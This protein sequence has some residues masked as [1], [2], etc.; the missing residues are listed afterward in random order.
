MG[1]QD[2]H[3][4]RSMP[5]DF[6]RFRH[7]TRTYRSPSTQRSWDYPL[8]IVGVSPFDETLDETAGHV[9]H[10]A[11]PRFMARWTIKDNHVYEDAAAARSSHYDEDMGILLT[12]IT[13]L[14]TDGGALTDWLLEAVCAVAYSR[15]TICELQ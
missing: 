11:E 14:E 4:N 12:E 6:H 10:I 7:R 8:W 15:G 1:S 2:H 5:L 9:I 13:P 3:V